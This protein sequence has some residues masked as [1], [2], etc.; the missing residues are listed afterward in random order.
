MYVFLH[1]PN[2]SVVILRKLLFQA[3]WTAIW[4]SLCSKYR[5]LNVIKMALHNRIYNESE[6]YC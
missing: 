2:H 5:H 3:C 6:L 4:K 1:K